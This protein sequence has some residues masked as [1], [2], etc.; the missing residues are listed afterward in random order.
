MNDEII[1]FFKSLFGRNVNFTVTKV[2]QY[3]TFP[4]WALLDKDDEH[5][6]EEWMEQFENHFNQFKSSLEKVLRRNNLMDNKIGV[7]IEYNIPGYR[8]GIHGTLLW[9]HKDWHD[10][11][12][13]G[14]NPNS[15]VKDGLNIQFK[16]G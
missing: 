15:Y 4:G 6:S 10:G 5:F 3:D 11:F 9:C 1:S 2:Y 14:C 16:I 7:V 12:F 13:F 8:T